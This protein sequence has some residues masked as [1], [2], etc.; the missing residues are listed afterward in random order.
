MANDL[1]KKI[2]DNWKALTVI[3]TISIASVSGWNY[4]MASAA[5][6]ARKEVQATVNKEMIDGAK[7][8]AAEAVREQLPAIAKEVAQ[9]VAKQVVEAQKKEKVDK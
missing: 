5:E 7:K 6:T 4:A 2:S 1:L 9:E 8:A 3:G